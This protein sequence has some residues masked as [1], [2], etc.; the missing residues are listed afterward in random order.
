MDHLSFWRKKEE[1]LGTRIPLFGSL[2]GYLT[3][4]FSII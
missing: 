1:G 2:F 4:L 3:D